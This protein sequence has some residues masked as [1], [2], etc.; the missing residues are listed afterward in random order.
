MFVD[1]IGILLFVVFWLEDQFVEDESEVLEILF[2]DYLFFWCNI[3][4]GKVEVYVVMLFWC[5]LVLL[6]CDVIGVMW[7]EFQ[8]EDEE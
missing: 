2:V 7:D 1:Y 8:E 4:F 5:I 6:M 3:F